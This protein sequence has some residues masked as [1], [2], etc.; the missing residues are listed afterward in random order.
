MDLPNTEVA[1]ITEAKIVR[2]LL[3]STHVSGKGKAG[4]FTRFG[5]SPKRWQIMADALKLHAQQHRV[6]KTEQSPFGVRYVIEGELMTPD[7]RNP[8]VRAIWFIDKGENIP[9]FVTAYPLKE[10][11]P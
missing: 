11:Q 5:F 9:R 3:S 6:S 7:G 8:L 10:G 4:F 2:Y 1:V